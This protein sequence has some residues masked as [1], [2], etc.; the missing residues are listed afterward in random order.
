MEYLIVTPICFV[1]IRL[2]DEIGK[3]YRF[4]NHFK[5]FPN[6]SLEKLSQYEEK[7]KVKF[8]LRKNEN[9]H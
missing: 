6:E 9:Q 3:N 2:I 5:I 7:S 8:Y 4:K 1:L